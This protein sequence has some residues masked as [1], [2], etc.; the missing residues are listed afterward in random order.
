MFTIQEHQIGIS[1]LSRRLTWK[2]AN[3]TSHTL[4][5]WPGPGF[6]QARFWGWGNSVKCFQLMPPSNT[7]FESFSELC[8]L[9]VTKGYTGLCLS[10]IDQLGPWIS[11]QTTCLPCMQ[12]SPNAVGPLVP[13]SEFQTMDVWIQLSWKQAGDAMFIFCMEVH[14]SGYSRIVVVKHLGF[15]LEWCCGGRKLSQIALQK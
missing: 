15:L 5:V 10:V 3:M 8:M 7:N 1:W 11:T 4:G 12:W 2:C 13:E 9:T 6:S 14:K